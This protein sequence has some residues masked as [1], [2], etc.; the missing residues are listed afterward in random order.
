[1]MPLH[2]GSENGHAVVVE[3]LI[4]AGADVSAVD[5]VS[6]CAKQYSYLCLCS[7]VHNCSIMQGMH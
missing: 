3:A 4:R 6:W 7:Y 2:Y 1:M 5:K